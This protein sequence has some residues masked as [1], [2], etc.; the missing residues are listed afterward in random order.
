MKKKLFLRNAQC[1]PA[2]D[3]SSPRDPAASCTWCG[4]RGTVARVFFTRPQAAE[5]FCRDCWPA[6]R[7]GLS[8][9]PV[10]SYVSRAWSD[11]ERLITVLPPSTDA[12]TCVT[13]AAEIVATAWDM[14]GPVPPMVE[15]FLRRVEMGPA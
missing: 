10:Q 15:K 14:D 4:C 9:R 1:I 12:R 13:L 11:V 3:G 7:E 6:A 8:D 5:R 2:D